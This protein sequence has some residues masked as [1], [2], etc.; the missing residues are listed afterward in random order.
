LQKFDGVFRMSK[1]SAMIDS[2]DQSISSNITTFKAYVEMSPKYNVAAEYKLNLVNPI[3]SEGVPV[4]A[5]RS[6]GFYIDN[7]DTVYYLD[8]DGNGLIRVFSVVSTT[9]QKVIRN[10]SIGTID[11]NSGKIAINGLK[12]LNLYEPNFYFIFKTSSYDV[13]SVR[14]QIVDIPDSRI[15]VNIVED[16]I[17]A[18]T[19]KGG[20]NYIFTKSRN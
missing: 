16:S 9:G 18:G 7:S 8:D 11:Y 20:T 2:L 5:F 15:T 3:Y 6:T 17:A 13:I 4:E 14:N 12:I 1:F 19:Y 10:A